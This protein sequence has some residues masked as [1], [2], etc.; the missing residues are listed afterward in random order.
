MPGIVSAE[1]IFIAAMMIL[2]LIVSF[3][4]VYFFFKTY[5]KEM[6]EK[7]EAKGKAK[8]KISAVKEDAS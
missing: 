4:S 3:A 6:K 8:N 2:I 5:K 1:V 7:L